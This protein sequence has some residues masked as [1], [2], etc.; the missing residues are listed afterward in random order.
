MLKRSSIDPAATAFGGFT[1]RTPDEWSSQ[2]TYA[3]GAQVSHAGAA[4]VSLQ[5]TNLNHMPADG[6]SAYWRLLSRG[7]RVDDSTIRS[8]AP[9]LYA[10]YNP[11]TSTLD[12]V[13]GVNPLN[14][15]SEAV[16]TETIIQQ[17]RSL[18][19]EY[20]KA[21]TKEPKKEAKP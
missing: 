12:V 7:D 14:R 1:A 18:V 3:E 19:D 10:L 15:E 6:P 11:Q 16:Q 13:R 2:I 4:W 9:G 20:F 17:Y 8:L 5:A 21:I